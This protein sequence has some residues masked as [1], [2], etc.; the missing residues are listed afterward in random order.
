MYRSLNFLKR[1][2]KWILEILQLGDYSNN[3]QKTFS[4]ILENGIVGY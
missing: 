1:K 3:L 2:I 4:K